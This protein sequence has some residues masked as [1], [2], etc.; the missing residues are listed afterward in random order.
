MG[1][2]IKPLP[3]QIPNPTPVP[4]AKH[5][6]FG[7]GAYLQKLFCVAKNVRKIVCRY[8]VT[9]EN[10]NGLDNK[11]QERLLVRMAHRA[12]KMGRPVM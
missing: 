6:V 3:S 7:R 1:S 9:K 8:G 4:M 12:E 2:T 5:T 11:I 10:T